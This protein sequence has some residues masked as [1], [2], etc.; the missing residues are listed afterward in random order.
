MLNIATNEQ[1]NNYF[2]EIT[3]NV[4][5]L[6]SQTGNAFL[7]KLNPIAIEKEDSLELKIYCGMEAW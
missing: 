4:L 3:Q 2:F 5:H 1:K 6:H 7:K